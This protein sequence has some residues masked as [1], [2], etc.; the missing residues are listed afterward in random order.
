MHTFHLAELPARMTATAMVRPPKTPGLLAAECLAGM[1]LGAPV[2]SPDRLQLR[3][4]VMFAAWRDEAA[5]DNFL[6]TD[7]LG[8]RLADGWHLRLEFVRRWGKVTEFADLPRNASRTDP[9]EP[10]VAVTLARMRLPE[11]PRFIAWGRGVERQVRDHPA[12]TLSSAAIRPPRTV[13]TF[14]I[15]R[16][17]KE[18][19]EMVFGHTDPATQAAEVSR[20]HHR[21]MAE[22]ERRDFHHEFTTL[23]F[24]A[25]SEHG[26]WLGRSNYLPR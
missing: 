18:M 7:P 11:L 3:R 2:I 24:R 22:R 8:R 6:L 1:R 26:T 20:R 9:D 21:A 17:A 25:L 10:V 14:S 4:F 5:V 15:W 19:T 13:S 23:R 12:A 16:S